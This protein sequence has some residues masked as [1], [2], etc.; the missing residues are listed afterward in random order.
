MSSASRYAAGYRI[1]QAISVALLTV[2]FGLAAAGVQ[3]ATASTT[4]YAF[5]MI[6]SH[7]LGHTATVPD[8]SCGGVAAG[9]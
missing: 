9:C 5:N 4:V 7:Q 8:T 6:R 1:R 3:I 2:T